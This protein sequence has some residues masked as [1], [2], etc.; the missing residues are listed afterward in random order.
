MKVRS[1]KSS[2]REK[3]VRSASISAYRSSDQSTRS[4][5]FTATTM[6]GIP[7]RDEMKPCRLDWVRSPFRASTRMMA[8]SAVDAPVT[9]LRVYCTC[10]GVSAMMNFRFGVAKYR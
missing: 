10:P 3:S 8:S 1:S 4:I 2:F 6:C 5:L 9:M 7:S